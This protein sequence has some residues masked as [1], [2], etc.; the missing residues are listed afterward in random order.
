MKGARNLCEFMTP[1]VF[2]AAGSH[3]LKSPLMGK[4]APS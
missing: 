3:A 1:E 4:A 2:E